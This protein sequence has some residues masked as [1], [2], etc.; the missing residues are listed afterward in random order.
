LQQG[1]FVDS[2]FIETWTDEDR[3]PHY[4]LFASRWQVEG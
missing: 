3:L 4:K 1:H 2:Q